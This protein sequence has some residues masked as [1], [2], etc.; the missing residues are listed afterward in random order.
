MV[1]WKRCRRGACLASL[2]PRGRFLLVFSLAA[3]AACAEQTTSS[4]PPYRSPDTAGASRSEPRTLGP[5]ARSTAPQGSRVD[6]EIGTDKFINPSPGPDLTPPPIELA[7]TGDYTVNMVDVPVEQAARA[8]LG[9]TLGL[10]FV[11]GA[12]PGGNITV[13]TSR[14]VSKSNLFEIFELALAQS[15]Y[16][17]T[18]RNDTYIVASD[19]TGTKRFQLARRPVAAGGGVYVI[20]L[21]FIS[22]VEMGRI[23][24]SIASPSLGLGSSQTGN[25]LFAAGGRSDIEAVLDAVNIFDV[26]VMRGKSVSRIQLTAADPKAVAEELEAVFDTG[27]GGALEGVLRFLP[28]ETLNSILII[29]S[30]ARY[31][32]E[33]E[34]LV[35]KYDLA[36]GANRQIA[37]VYRLENRAAVELAPVMEKLLSFGALAVDGGSADAPTAVTAEPAAASAA[38]TAGG[39]A[40]ATEATGLITVSAPGDD[41]QHPVINSAKIVADDTA[42]ALIVHATPGEHEDIAKLVRRLDSVAHQVLIEATIAEVELKDELDFGIRWFFESGDFA[43]NFS[44]LAASGVGAI[45]PGF[46]AVFDSRSGAQVALDALAQIT[47]V[48]I[49]SSP[50]LLV[51]DNRQAVLNVGDQVPIVTQSAV[52]VSDPDAPIVNSVEQ[53]DTGVILTIRPRV[54]TTGRVIL[55]IK[56][57]VSDVVETDT[58]GIDSPTIQQRVVTTTVAVDDGQ[59]IVLGGLIR[60]FRTRIRNQVPLL[61][62]IPVLGSLFRS[63]SDDDRRTELL[64]IITPR[65]VRDSSKARRITDEY[66]DLLSGPSELINTRRTGAKHQFR[67]LFY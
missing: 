41:E 35:R 50:S 54:S 32:A 22:A 61:G 24:Q 13:Q 16:S 15:G 14:P 2:Y 26:D 30:R 27:Q 44:S 64:V 53:R 3:L 12:G 40:P 57:E 51:L 11:V 52:N 8:V 10:N 31:I 49:I 42:N 29:S 58:S 1:V 45:L 48:D 9:D 21:E 34:D 25:L 65:V 36:A 4:G 20:P 39:A 38:P 47:D 5:S 43:T 59:S 33:A 19:A 55:E 66:R 67:R 23:L 37:V 18:L 6:R 46:N 60:E 62:D 7:D 63:V 56:Q 17:I 28:N